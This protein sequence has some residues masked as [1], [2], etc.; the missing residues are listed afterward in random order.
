MEEHGWGSD[1]WT[2][3]DFVL[4]DDP[5]F[6]SPAQMAEKQGFKSLYPTKEL[7][8]SWEVF[9]LKNGQGTMRPLIKTETTDNGQAGA[10]LQVTT[11]TIPYSVAE[12]SKIQEKYS[13]LAQKTET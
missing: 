2:D 10:I 6:T 11:Q 1:D 4:D 8:I 3:L 7:E 9:Y 5:R 13:R 12:L